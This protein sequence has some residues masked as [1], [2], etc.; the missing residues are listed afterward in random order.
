MTVRVAGEGQAGTSKG[1]GPQVSG[2]SSS[3]KAWP[4][5]SVP[6]MGAGGMATW[7]ARAG[8]WTDQTASSFR[9]SRV[10][11]VVELEEPLSDEGGGRSV[12]LKSSEQT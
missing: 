8:F 3:D 7:V 1:E 9:T 12:G 6:A 11:A 5:D 2:T 10:E 4:Q